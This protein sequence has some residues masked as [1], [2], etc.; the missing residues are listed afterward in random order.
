MQ[1]AVSI[2]ITAVVCLGAIAAAAQVRQQGPVVI[3]G[4]LS[5]RESGSSLGRIRLGAADPHW[6]SWQIGV[7]ARA[8]PKLTFV[9]AAAR[10]DALGVAVI[11]GYSGQRVSYEIPKNL[12]HNLQSGERTAILGRLRELAIRMP[13]YYVEKLPSDAAERRKLFEFAKAMGVET[14]ICSP[15]PSALAELDQLA[16]E[17][18]VNVAVRGGGAGLEARSKRI[19]VSAAR[20]VKSALTDRLLAV[21]VSPADAPGLSDFL[22]EAYRA[23]RKPLIITVESGT[24]ADLDALEKALQPAMKARVYQVADSPHGQI[25]R[26]DRLSAEV[27]AKIDAAIPRQPIVKP[28]KLRKLLVVDLNMWSGHATIP[29]GNLMLELFAKYTGAFEPTFSNDLTNLKYDKI[30]QYDAV[31]LNSVVGMVFPDPEVRDGLMRFAREG[32]GLGGVHGT[33]YAAL[34]WPEFTD[35]LGGSAGEHRVEKQ[36]LRI[37]DPNSPLTAPF[38]G[39]GFEHT[40]EFYHFPP[41]RRSTCC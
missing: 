7:P 11:E 1:R 9:E 38:G 31:F 21:T 25:R 16:T 27:R 19:G 14:I 40:D 26:P 5:V 28:K 17:Y 3:P 13:S 37:D 20:A 22:L 4:S 34:D 30:K 12:D 6:F 2:K 35:M 24:A 32:G 33:T 18:G 36:V 23:E 10:A 8:F 39:T 29:H 15:E 41:A